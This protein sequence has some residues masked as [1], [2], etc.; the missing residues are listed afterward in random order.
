[1]QFALAY[2]IITRQNQKLCKASK[3]A[4]KIVAFL[5]IFF[6]FCYLCGWS[7]RNAICLKSLEDYSGFLLQIDDIDLLVIFAPKWL[8]LRFFLALENQLRQ[9]GV[10]P[11]D[12]IFPASLSLLEKERDAP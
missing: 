8:V 11:I 7:F 6:G 9:E 5:K 1:V 10:R 4:T 2:L 3:I 12:L